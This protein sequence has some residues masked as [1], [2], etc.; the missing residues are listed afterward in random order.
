[1]LL[2]AAA[3]QRQSTVCP[4]GSITYVSELATPVGSPAE[5]RPEV[6][7][8]PALVEIKGKVIAVDRVIRGPLCNAEW[9]GTVYVACD[10]EI[11]EWL[12]SPG[13]L[14]ACPFEVKPGSTVYVAAHNDTAYYKGCSCH[15]GGLSAP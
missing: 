14:E 4:E 10:I 1:V 12:E 6:T 15:T 7:P 9:T 8:T 2:L 5:P 3:C 11:L 13:F